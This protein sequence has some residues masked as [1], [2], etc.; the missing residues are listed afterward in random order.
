MNVIK[1]ILF[2]L[3]SLAAGIGIFIWILKL[4]GWEKIKMAF[5]VFTGWQG[6]V[7]LILT[8][9]MAIIGNWKWREILRDKGV[10]ISFIDLLKAYL[11]GFSMMFFAPI[12]LWGGEVFRGYIIK[13]YS[14]VSWSRGT[15]S[16]IIDR[17][18]EWTTNL[19][20]IFVGTFYFILSTGVSLRS[21]GLTIGLAFI[22]F[23][24]IISFFYFKSYKKESI[25][26]FLM[27]S[28]YKNPLEIEMEI[29]D[30]FRLSKMAMWKGFLISG[31]RAVVMYFRTWILIFF[32]GKSINPLSALSILG[33]SYLAAM[34]PIP[35]A[36]GS[37][38]AI[39]TFSFNVLGI[40]ASAAPVFTMIIRASELVVALSL[41]HI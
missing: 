17:V 26:R 24:I 9:L 3:I 35:A 22:F 13:K 11:A 41:I 36:I 34:I 12:M 25:V 7:I 28:D 8:F 20:V 37:H 39:Q 21:I 2:F 14:S 15:A 23:I 10:E 27:R 18:L 32:L 16:V 40:G 29:F 4:V 6:L 33:F 31:L 38:E 30:Y 5:A 19:I 1:K